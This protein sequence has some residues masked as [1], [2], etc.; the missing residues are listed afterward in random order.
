MKTNVPRLLNPKPNIKRVVE[1]KK[2][3][4][5]HALTRLEG[6]CREED[7]PTSRYKQG[8]IHDPVSKQ[9]KELANNEAIIVKASENQV[10]R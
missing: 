2:F 1:E 10:E 4:K 8:K 5:E 6:S 9:A 7:L 3:N